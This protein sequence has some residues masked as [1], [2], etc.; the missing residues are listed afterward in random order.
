MKHL[1]SRG[2]NIYYAIMA[3]HQDKN[4]YHNFTEGLELKYLLRVTYLQVEKPRLEYR[5]VCWPMFF[6]Y[7]FVFFP[8][9]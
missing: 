9:P 5:Y 8:V 1:K 6:V 7:L 3:F 2:L 4:Y